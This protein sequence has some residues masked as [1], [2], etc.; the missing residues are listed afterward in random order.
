MIGLGGG[1]GGSPGFGAAAAGVC[2]AAPGGVAGIV[3]GA[4][5]AGLLAFE[6]AADFDCDVA[7]FF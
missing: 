6:D 7:P 4:V 2:V 3:A 5:D 1:G